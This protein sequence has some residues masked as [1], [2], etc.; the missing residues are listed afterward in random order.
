[1]FWLL[2]NLRGCFECLEWKNLV[3]KHFPKSGRFFKTVE[4]VDRTEQGAGELGPLGSAGRTGGLPPRQIKLIGWNWML[5]AFVKSL[6]TCF[7]NAVMARALSTLRTTFEVKSLPKHSQFLGYFECHFRFWFYWT[8]WRVFLTKMFYSFHLKVRSRFHGDFTFSWLPCTNQW[9]HKSNRSERIS[10]GAVQPPLHRTPR[11]VLVSER[12][13]SS[14]TCEVV[15][16]VW[17]EKNMVW[18]HF[19]KCSHFFK[20]LEMVGGT[21]Q[22]AGELGPLAGVNS[23]FHILGSR[24]NL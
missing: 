5:R 14:E 24:N 10:N 9:R 2:W 7:L 18:R 21:E 13:G 19:R 4:I 16:S 6:F 1:M 23:C 12:F 11:A 22:G 15:L 20:S 17:S 8:F 3:Q